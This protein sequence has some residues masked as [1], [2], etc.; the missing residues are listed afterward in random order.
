[1]SVG[2]FVD[3][4]GGYQLVNESE[5]HARQPAPAASEPRPIANLPKATS[6]APLS[7][8]RKALGRSTSLNFDSSSIQRRDTANRPAQAHSSQGFGGS[9]AGPHHQWKRNSSADVLARA[10]AITKAVGSGSTSN[11]VVSIVPPR[12]VV[13]SSRP[14]AAAVPT[15]TATAVDTEPADENAKLQAEIERLRVAMR[16][17]ELKAEEELLSYKREAQKRQGETIGVRKRLEE[18]SPIL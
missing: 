1:M 13:N 9:Q 6:P 10:Q 5:G 17:T 18:V 11:G 16:Q 7:S 8:E 3:D 14:P 4:N 15:T 2:V 12:P